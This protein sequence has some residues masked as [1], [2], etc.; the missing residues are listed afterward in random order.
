ML[1]PVQAFSQVVPRE[2]TI[3]QR[4]CMTRQSS[5]IILDDRRLFN[6]IQRALAVS[7][8]VTSYL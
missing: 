2:F 3:Y 6:N 1:L 7:A 5:Q 4:I 8:V